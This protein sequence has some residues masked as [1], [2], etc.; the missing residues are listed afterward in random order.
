MSLWICRPEQVKHPYYMELLGIHLY[1]SQELSYVIYNNPLL[2]LEG[3]IDDNLL[4]FLRDELNHGF[5]ALKIERWLKSNENPDDALILLLQEF[6]YYTTAEISGYRHQLQVLRKLPADEF[7]K[8]KADSLFGIRQYGK[9]LAQYQELLKASGAGASG[10]MTGKLMF[11]IGS[12]Y[13]RMFYTEKA[14]EAYRKA[15]QITKDAGVL[16][17]LYH[18]T[19]LDPSLSLDEKDLAKIT[20]EQM[21]TWDEHL[22]KAKE[23][24]LQSD[25]VQQLNELF[26]KDS[27]RRQAGMAML[28]AKWKREY[29]SMV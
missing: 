23:V 2:V 28:V 26:T 8:K 29:R 6:D 14:F 15:Y 24:A 17:R 9:A 12:C 19:L 21:V 25:Q 20:P 16:E 13:A 7:K 27:L 3:F 10:E 5:L 22:A 18:L 1:S 11:N 4:M